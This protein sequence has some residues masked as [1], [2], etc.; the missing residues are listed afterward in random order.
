MADIEKK[1]EVSPIEP[2]PERNSR[3]G[4]IVKVADENESPID[5]N[6]VPEEKYG[7]FRAE[8]RPPLDYSS[9]S[10]FLNSLCGRFKSLWTRRFIYALLVSS[11]RPYRS[12][13]A[14]TESATIFPK[15]G[16]LVS[17]CI[18]CTNITTTELV[19]RVS[20]QSIHVPNASLS[21]Y[22]GARDSAIRPPKPSSCKFLYRQI[23]DRHR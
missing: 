23:R 10:A 6:A 21:L 19:K 12:T 13:Y 18:T 14:C 15:A 3:S 22:I 1:P 7:G 20:R 4:S 5:P 9:F 11:R 17:L 16:Q 2:V 8:E